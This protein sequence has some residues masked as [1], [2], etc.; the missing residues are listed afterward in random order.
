MVI[1]LE[2]DINMEKSNKEN[3]AKLSDGEIKEIILKSNDRQL[4][5]FHTIAQCDVIMAYSQLENLIQKENIYEYIKNQDEKEILSNLYNRLINSFNKNNLDMTEKEIDEE[6]KE[7]LEIRKEL[8]SLI[9]AM[10]GYEIELSYVIE[11]LNYQMMKSSGKKEYKNIKIDDKEIE[12]IVDIIE[13]ELNSSIHQYDAFIE[14]VS[15][16]LGIVPFRMSKFKYFNIIESALK[17]NFS[18]YPLNHVETKIESYKLT[19][20][21][22]LMGDYGVLFDYC[23]AEIQKFKNINFKTKSFV[24]LEN[25]LDEMDILWNE[26]LKIK[27]FIYIQGILSNKLIGCI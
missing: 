11:S 17:R 10:E 21:S 16:V 15:K 27:T 22:S 20:D 14:K 19:F 3:I 7:L 12:Y 24:E 13:G 5:F 2:G 4:S 26:I 25:I 8:Y 6:I 23:F 1:Y 9:S 18:N